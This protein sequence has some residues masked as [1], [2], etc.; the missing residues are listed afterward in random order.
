MVDDPDDQQQK[1]SPEVHVYRASSPE[2]F[3]GPEDAEEVSLLGLLNVLLRHRWKVLGLIVLT[4]V[5][6]VGLGLLKTPSYTSQAS[7]M[8]QLGGDGAG[9]FS[10][11]SGVA[12][13]FGIDVPTREAG[14]SPQFYAELVTSRRILSAAVTTEYSVPREGETIQ[15]DLVEIFRIEAETEDRA[16]EKAIARLR[17]AVSVTTGRETGI[18]RVSVTTSSAELSGQIAERLI[19]LVN[20]FNL[21]VRQSQ[22]SAQAEFVGER[23]EQARDELRAAEDSLE[24]FLERNRSFQNS[25]T[26]QFEHQRLQRQVDLKQ[27][28]FSSLASRYEEAQI[29]EVRNTP[30]ITVVTPARVPASPDPSGLY[31]RGIFG[32][33][34]GGMVGVF[35]AF[36]AEFSRKARDQKHDEYREFVSLKDEILHD[37]RLIG[38]RLGSMG[39]SEG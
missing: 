32:L 13:Q 33:L 10:R 6:F 18:V 9:Q 17:E 3:S 24:Q 39:G 20:Q 27:Q 15:S 12:S 11:L 4:A 16:L 36:M 23:L 8:P 35:W 30:V 28:V 26:L 19:G 7:F 22:A 2:V 21:E 14:G 31:I 5:G 29:S 25:P 37:L 1:G 38:R 34:L